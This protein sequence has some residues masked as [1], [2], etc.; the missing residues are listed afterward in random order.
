MRQTLQAAGKF[1]VL[2]QCGFSLKRCDWP[3]LVP[4]MGSFMIP[5]LFSV[6]PLRECMVPTD[7]KK[8]EGRKRDGELC[9]LRSHC[10]F[11]LISMLVAPTE[12][13][14]NRSFQVCLHLNCV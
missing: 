7:S 8:D 1:R 14:V 5:G 2:L 9:A 6:V 13:T 11:M 3:R 10:L 12:L 4:G